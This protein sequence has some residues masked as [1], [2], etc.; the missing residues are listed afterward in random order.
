[1]DL[2]FEST[3]YLGLLCKTKI[4]TWLPDFQHKYYPENFGFISFGKESFLIGLEL[5]LERGISFKYR[6]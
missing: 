5:K 6:C 3:E 4:I 2:L 1:M